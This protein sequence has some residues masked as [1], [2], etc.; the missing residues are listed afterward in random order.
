MVWYMTGSLSE[1]EDG[2][3]S[4]ELKS[5]VPRSE[6]VSSEV[7]VHELNYVA[8]NKCFIVVFK[9]TVRLIFVE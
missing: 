9:T 7:Q 6:V 4:E 8:K 1:A 2:H 3:I 5:E